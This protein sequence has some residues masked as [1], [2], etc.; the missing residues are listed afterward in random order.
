MAPLLRG[1]VVVITG[2]STGIGRAIALEC[3]R[4]GAKLVLHHIGDAQ[5]KQDIQTLR[6]EID[7]I[8]GAPATVTTA[9]IGV[10]ITDPEAGKRIIDIAISTFKEV[11]AIV[12]N[13]G[14]AQFEDFT[15]ISKHQLNKHI[16]INFAGP[17][18]ITQAIVQQM[19]TQGKGGAVVSI[20]S[21]TATLGSSQLVHYSATKAA[22]LGMTVSC[23]VALGKHGIRFNTVS[24]GTIETAINRADLA[25]L[26]R[27]VM[28]ERVPLR[29]LGIPEDI[30]QPVVFF[31]SDMAQYISG[32][33][34]I[35][36]GGAS[37][38]YQ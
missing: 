33:N 21:I 9:E 11:N 22:I 37:I 20:A 38:N 36:D 5:S 6:T 34:L 29:R 4:H 26:K 7:A 17:F 25:G 10:D 35:V 27:R 12:H 19:I 13:A 31:I 14:I 18:A 8:Q 32:Q 24:P 30:A 2:S 15:A 1:K 3:A 16:E 28:E 23:A